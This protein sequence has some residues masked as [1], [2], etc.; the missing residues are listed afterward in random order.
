[1]RKTA[2][3][4][5]IYNGYTCNYK[6]SRAHHIRIGWTIFTKR[7]FKSLQSCIKSIRTKS[8][9]TCMLVITQGIMFSLFRSKK[10]NRYEI[11]WP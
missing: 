1:M 2:E 8:I 9:N 6:M 4:N 7:A 11:K 3:H 5:Y 10:W